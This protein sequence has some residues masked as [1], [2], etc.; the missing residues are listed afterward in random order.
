MVQD[1]LIFPWRSAKRSAFSHDPAYIFEI[2][3]CLRSLR[4]IRIDRFDRRTEAATHVSAEALHTS[5]THRKFTPL[6]TWEG[7]LEDDL[8]SVFPSRPRPVK[9]VKSQATTTSPTATEDGN[10]TTFLENDMV[11][12]V[13]K[14]GLSCQIVMSVLLKRRFSAPAIVMVQ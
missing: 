9:R 8:A 12:K 2:T 7:R 4:D 14:Q 10:N 11:A 5:Y 1:L 6:V 13:V 3:D